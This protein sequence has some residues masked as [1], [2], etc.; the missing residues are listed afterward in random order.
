[1]PG[2]GEAWNVDSKSLK[3]FLAAL[4]VRTHNKTEL[5]RQGIIWKAILFGTRE[6]EDLT[7]FGSCVWR[8]GEGGVWF[9]RGLGKN[10]T[11]RSNITL[12]E[13]GG[14][15]WR[16]IYCQRLVSAEGEMA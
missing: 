12:L 13:K 3:L 7:G 14:S 9:Q 8:V 11:R 6:K 16:R 15:L 2:L 10:L 1:M 4:C 5:R